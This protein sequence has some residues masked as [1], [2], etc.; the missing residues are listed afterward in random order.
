MATRTLIGDLNPK[1]LPALRQSLD[2][3]MRR[4]GRCRELV[5]STLQPDDGEWQPEA[6]GVWQTR[7]IR[8]PVKRREPTR[9]DLAGALRE[10]PGQPIPPV[11]IEY[12]ITSFILETGPRKP[13][14]KQ[15]KRSTM[16]DV[17]IIAFYQH[18]LHKAKVRKRSD[19]ISAPAT[20]AKKRTAKKFGCSVRT[21]E[22]IIKSR[23]PLSS[24]KS[25]VRSQK[26]S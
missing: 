2:E 8:R 3:R 25:S 26:S 22:S 5:L 14:P 24:S 18:Q 1:A 21:I 6:N 20:R 7:I 13:G 23:P 4:E 9:A 15:P 16:L 10:S 17:E 19:V 11:L 12:I